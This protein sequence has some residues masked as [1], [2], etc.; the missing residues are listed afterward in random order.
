MSAYDSYLSEKLEDFEMPEEE[1][2]RALARLPK[3]D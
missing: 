1:I 3:V 2:K